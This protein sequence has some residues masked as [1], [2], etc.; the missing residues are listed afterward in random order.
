MIDRQDI[1]D[2][3]MEYLMKQGWTRDDAYEAGCAIADELIL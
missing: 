2:A 3:V 1:K